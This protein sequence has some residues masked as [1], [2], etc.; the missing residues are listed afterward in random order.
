[1]NVNIY[2]LSIFAEGKIKYKDEVYARGFRF[3]TFDYFTD[4]DTHK[5]GFGL[6]LWNIG[7]SISKTTE[8]IDE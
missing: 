6:R 8:Y 2:G 3:Y 1:M 5:I 4:E 7:I